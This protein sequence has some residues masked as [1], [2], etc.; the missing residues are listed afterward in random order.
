MKLRV[1]QSD[2]ADFCSGLLPPPEL[3]VTYAADSFGSI[4][5]VALPPLARSRLILDSYFRRSMVV[6]GIN[7]V[8]AILRVDVHANP[9]GKFFSL[10]F[11]Y[12][13]ARTSRTIS[14][15]FRQNH[16]TGRAAGWAMTISQESAQWTIAQPP[17]KSTSTKLV[18]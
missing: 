12:H 10:I 14:A 16:P 8:L 13:T 15:P 1:Y 18:V 4:R 5:D 2:Y 17:M 7:K 6:T 3:C 9:A 11:Y